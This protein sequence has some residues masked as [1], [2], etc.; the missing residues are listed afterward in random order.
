MD[1]KIKKSKILYDI[2]KLLFL[3]IFLKFFTFKEN[4]KTKDI[5]LCVIA[6]NENLL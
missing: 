1:F 4:L 6:K 5:A 2:F 3:F